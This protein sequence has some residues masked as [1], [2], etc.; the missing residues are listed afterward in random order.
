[1]LEIG[2][3]GHRESSAQG[4]S[5]DGPAWGRGLELE[6]T[7]TWGDRG[8]Q[9][10]NYS[11]NAN[12][13]DTGFL[14][15]PRRRVTPSSPKRRA[16]TTWDDASSYQNKGSPS[17]SSSLQSPALRGDSSPVRSRYPV[18]FSHAK[19]VSGKKE[20]NDSVRVSRGVT[21]GVND[22]KITTA[23]GVRRPLGGH[24][25]QRYHHRSCCPQLTMRTGLL[26]T[27]I[28]VTLVTLSR[29]GKFSG[30][31]NNNMSNRRG[32]ERFTV[33]GWGRESF[34]GDLGKGDTGASKIEEFPED[35]LA[36]LEN[37]G[38]PGRM[39][40]PPG[41][42]PVPF[43]AFPKLRRSDTADVAAA[44]NGHSN[45]SDVVSNADPLLDGAVVDTPTL[46]FLHVWKCAGSSL[47]HLLRE[48]AALEKKKIAVVVRCEDA[49]A[50][51]FSREG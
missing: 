11:S 34:Q 7:P 12:C 41:E 18:D 8:G 5:S 13:G 42:R 46:M 36:V 19:R 40:I 31:D 39:W 10:R 29:A 1:M 14:T 20:E 27:V 30:G 37:D 16:R 23:A 50:V 32:G 15:S 35:A 44:G 21:V 2:N 33:D 28:S 4:H 51:R 3:T 17:G 49:I 22:P 45:G 47:R 25:Q 38:D 9:E 6:K 43:G 26:L 24:Q 48:W